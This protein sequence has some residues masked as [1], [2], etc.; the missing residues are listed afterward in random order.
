MNLIF[1]GVLSLN[2]GEAV[3]KDAGR[4]ERLTRGHQA[5]LRLVVVGV[6]LLENIQSNRSC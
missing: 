2:D 1:R 5:V 3:V 6:G 4:R